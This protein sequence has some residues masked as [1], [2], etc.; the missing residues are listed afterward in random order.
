MIFSLLFSSKKYEEN[1]EEKLK[2]IIKKNI[3]GEFQ[4]SLYGNQLHL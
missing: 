1:N 3:S 4:Q 2:K